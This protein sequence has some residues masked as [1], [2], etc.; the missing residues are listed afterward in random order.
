MP[1]ADVVRSGSQDHVAVS[2]YRSARVTG[3]NSGATQAPPQPGVQAEPSDYVLAGGENVPAPS[4]FNVV[5]PVFARPVGAQEGYTSAA[6]ALAAGPCA[7]RQPD[8]STAHN[9]D[10]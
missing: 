8:R 3:E 2:Y 10:P 4:P 5:T 9:R 6:T 1:A 7:R